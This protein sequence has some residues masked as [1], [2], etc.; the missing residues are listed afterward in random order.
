MYNSHAMTTASRYGKCNAASGA[1]TLFAL[2]LLSLVTQATTVC[3]A[4]RFADR[5][6]EARSH[7]NRG[8]IDEALEL[9]DGLGEKEVDSAAVAIGKSR[10]LES[11]GDWNEATELLET[12]VKQN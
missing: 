9:Y 8:R 5:L 10:C 7:L 4:D 1:R 6:A 3:A 12:A 2:L 11:R